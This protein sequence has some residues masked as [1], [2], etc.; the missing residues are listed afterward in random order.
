MLFQ[1][2]EENSIHWRRGQRPGEG[3]QQY[4]VLGTVVSGLVASCTRENNGARPCGRRRAAFSLVTVTKKKF[5]RRP[6]KHCT[7]S[8][9]IEHFSK[10]CQNGTGALE[11]LTILKWVSNRLHFYIFRGGDT[12]EKRGGTRRKKQVTKI[13]TRITHPGQ[14][15]PS[16]QAA[17]VREKTMAAYPAGTLASPLTSFYITI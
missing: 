17:H 7:F 15:L 5:D 8:K 13:S 11:I 12:A 3:A 2:L 4:M 1:N 10:F 14:G 16:P 6:Q 9:K